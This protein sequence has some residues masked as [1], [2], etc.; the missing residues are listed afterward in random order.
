MM[1]CHSVPLLLCCTLPLGS[2][3]SCEGK[4]WLHLYYHV[5]MCAKGQCHTCAVCRAL[6]REPVNCDPWEGW[7]PL[8]SPDSTRRQMANGLQRDAAEAPTNGLHRSGMSSSPKSTLKRSPFSRH[9]CGAVEALYWHACSA[10]RRLM[11]SIDIASKLSCLW[12][13]ARHRGQSAA[14]HPAGVFAAAK[15]SSKAHGS[16]LGSVLTL[17]CLPMVPLCLMLLDV[18]FRKAAAALQFGLICSS[19]LF[20]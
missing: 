15:H 11:C 14:A 12:C 9:A 8:P 13:R 17:L 2:Q 7:D 10:C 1:E 18:C 16:L 5:A 3:S 4:C 20:R 19:Q 6:S